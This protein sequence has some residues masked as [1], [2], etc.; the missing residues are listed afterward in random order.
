MEAHFN[1]AKAN[2][3]LPFFKEASLQF[4]FPMALLMAIASRET[5]MKNIRG[6]FRDGIFHG[7]G[8]MQVDIGTH[9]QWCR[10]GRWKDAREAI[11]KGTSVLADK[12][13]IMVQS[14]G[15]R[16]V[17]KSSKGGSFPFTAPSVLDQDYLRVLVPMYNGGLWPM[18]SYAQ[19]GNPDQYTTGKD[20][21][22]DVLARMAIFTTLLQATSQRE[23]RPTAAGSPAVLLQ[24]GQLAPSLPTQPAAAGAQPEALQGTLAAPVA[25]GG[26]SEAPTAVAAQVPDKTG[27]RKSLISYVG[28]AITGLGVTLASAWGTISTAVA[29][30]PKLMG[31]AI[32]G[33]L[34]ALAAYW[35]YQDRQTRMDLAREQQAHEINKLKLSLAADPKKINVDLMPHEQPAPEVT[36]EDQRPADAASIQTG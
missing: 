22:K 32:V 12:R 15:K 21:G 26:P 35:K 34:V 11:L 13:T 3:W 18:Y 17:V 20:Y 8:L 16:L 31:L 6:D 33:L 23:I 2:G 9:A 19:G 36:A 28:T 14:V 30:N 1:A 29:N 10:D 5:N 4:N 25:G 27:S 24:P 7:Y